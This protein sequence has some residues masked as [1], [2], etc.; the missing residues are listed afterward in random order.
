MSKNLPYLFVY[1]SQ[2]TLESFNRIHSVNKKT[3]DHLILITMGCYEALFLDGRAKNISRMLQKQLGD[4]LSCI[5]CNSKFKIKKRN[6]PELYLH[7]TFVCEVCGSRSEIPLYWL[8][9]KGN[10]ELIKDSE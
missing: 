10:M 4:L 1:I 7:E 9:A 8:L 2:V 3:V 6:A 5:H